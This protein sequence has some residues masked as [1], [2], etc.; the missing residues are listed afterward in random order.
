MTLKIKSKST[1]KILLKNKGENQAIHDRN[2]IQK[3]KL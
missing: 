3:R 1:N 2:I